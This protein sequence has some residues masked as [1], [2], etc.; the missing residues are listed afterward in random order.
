MGLAEEKET[1]NAG[2]QKLVT[3]CVPMTVCN[4]WPGVNVITQGD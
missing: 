4:Q 3:A 2:M 1:S